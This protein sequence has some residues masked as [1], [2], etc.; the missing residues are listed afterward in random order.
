MKLIYVAGPFRAATPWLIEQNIR[1]AETLALE[2]WKLG[3]P[4]LCPHTNTRFYQHSAPDE[5][6][7]QGDLVMLER[8]DAIVLV[9]GWEKSSGTKAE[10]E[11]AKSKGIPV[12]ES[13]NQLDLWLKNQ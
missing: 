9:E 4:A 1:K 12:F 5:L 3:V 7:L 10:I 2:V 11:H 6:W 13:L 8:C